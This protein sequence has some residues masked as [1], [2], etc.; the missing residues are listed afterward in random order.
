VAWEYTPTQS[1]NCKHDWKDL[2][3]IQSRHEL[4]KDSIQPSHTCPVPLLFTFCQQPGEN[5][6]IKYHVHKN[7]IDNYKRTEQD[8]RT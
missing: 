7:T 1:T 8:V 4:L 3:T 6:L 2:D 5:F